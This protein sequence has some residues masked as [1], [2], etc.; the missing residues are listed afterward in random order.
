MGDSECILSLEMLKNAFEIV[1]TNL[2]LA[3]SHRDKNTPHLPQILKNGETVMIKNHT[4][5]PFDPKY[6]DNYRI[7]SIR[8][9]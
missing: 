8:G 6:V 1:M 2:Q 5:G 7:V 3:R 9:H 4:A